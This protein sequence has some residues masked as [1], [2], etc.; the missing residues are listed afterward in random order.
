MSTVIVSPDQSGG[1][2]CPM[3]EVQRRLDTFLQDPCMD[4]GCAR[5][6]ASVSVLK[7]TDCLCASAG[8]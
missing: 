2:L 6:D 7:L 3:N 8:S 5:L 4:A 1:V